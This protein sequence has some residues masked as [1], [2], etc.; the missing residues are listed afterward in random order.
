MVARFFAPAL[1]SNAQVVDLP[2][3]EADHLRRVLR[4]GRGDVI[5]VFDGCGREYLARVET[6]DRRRVSIRTVEQLPAVPEPTVR[7]TLAASVLKGDKMDHV[8]RDATMLGVAVVQ[9]IV[10][11]HTEVPIAR[12]AKSTRLERW[13]RIAIS[14]AKQCGRAVVPEIRMPLA[15]GEWLEAISGERLP[16]R[17]RALL[18]FVEPGSRAGKSAE[19]LVGAAAPD[20]ATIAIGPE[21]GWSPEEIDASAAAGFDLLTLGHRIL[22]ADVAAAAIVSVLQFVWKDL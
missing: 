9:P 4:L 19:G 10:T 21:G 12:V 3:D 14:S 16:R 1:V 15:M 17:Q 11:A 7:L 18:M 2:E 8:V 6:A 22:R 5:G 13:H 20:S